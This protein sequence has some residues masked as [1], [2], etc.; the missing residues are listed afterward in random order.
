[1]NAEPFL[2]LGRITPL[3]I[4]LRHSNRPFQLEALLLGQ[5][6]LLEG[7]LSD[8]YVLQ[9][10]KEYAFLK[11]KY[12]LRPMNGQSWKFMRMRPVNFP[13]VRIAQMAAFLQHFQHA[14]S[15]IIEAENMEQIKELFHVSASDWWN[16]H[17]TLKRVSSKT[18]KELGP[19]SIENILINTV[20][21]LLFFYGRKRD[22]QAHCE[23]ALDWF[24]KI[25]AEDNHIT[26]MYGKV[27]FEPQ[28]AAHSQALIQ[29]HTNY[30]SKKKCLHCAI[31]AQAL[32]KTS[33]EA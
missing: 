30:C 22:S 25:N 29:L 17:Y 12:Q 32:R 20:C 1:V 3:E 26:R 18:R 4:L 31:G 14:F 15:R 24:R 5:A 21:P 19:S 6:G 11:H 23:K 27:L 8:P 2:H 33:I 9:L 28:H 13:T 7:D 10:Q 16:E